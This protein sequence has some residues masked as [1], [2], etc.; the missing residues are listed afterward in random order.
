MCG[1][2]ASP[3]QAEMQ[4]YWE[5]SHAR[6]RNPLTQTIN[7]TPT[8]IVPMLRLNPT[9]SLELVGARWG[10][11]P[12][13]WKEPK[14][15]RNTFNA[16]SEEAASTPM[17][18][19]PAGKARCLVP[20]LGWYEWKAVERVD[21]PAGEATTSK[22]PYFL[23]RADREPIA[24]AGLMSRRTAD[25]DT[26]EFSCTILTRDAAGPAADVHARMPIV[27]PKDAEGAWLNAEL[28]DAAVMIGFARESALTDFSV[29]PGPDL[30]ELF[31][32]P[33]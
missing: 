24:F 15:P 7:V 3:E 1:R 12:F 28:T 26:S 33:A 13:W 25:G 8:M 27:L 5:L 16:R 32:N 2:Y 10:L 18:R 11:I 6:V 9:G 14:P 23:R 29:H 30:F 19:I 20:A 4:R 22:Q 17:W 21:A 31:D